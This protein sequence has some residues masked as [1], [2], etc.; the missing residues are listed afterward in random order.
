M[1]TYEASS[2]YIQ[3]PPEEGIN[4]VDESANVR[5]SRSWK[6]LTGVMLDVIRAPEGGTQEIPTP[7]QVPSWK[8]MRRRHKHRHLNTS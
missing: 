2:A 3:L 8:S 4:Q 1:H 5:N 7:Q 6:Y